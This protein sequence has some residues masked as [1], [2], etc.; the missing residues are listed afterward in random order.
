[1]EL[2]LRSLSG[3]EYRAARVEFEAA[4]GP[5][6]DADLLHNLSLDGGEAGQIAAAIDYEE[7]FRSKAELSTAELDQARGD[8]S[9][10]VSWQAREA[11]SGRRLWRPQRRQRRQRRRRGGARGREG[12]GLVG[13]LGLLVGGGAALVAGWRAVERRSRRQCSCA[14]VRRLRCARSRR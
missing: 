7:R 11:E 14:P 2:G 13:A 6:G 12:G 9:G 1:M 8:W 5:S 10:C 4:H 3:G